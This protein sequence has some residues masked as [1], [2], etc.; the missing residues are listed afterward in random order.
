MTNRSAEKE[1][2]QLPFTFFVMFVGA[3]EKR[4][5]STFSVIP[6]YRRLAADA[7]FKV[8]GFVKSRHLLFL[9][10]PRRRE[11]SNFKNFW[12]P[13][14]RVRG[15]LI[16]KACP[17]LDPGSGMTLRGLFTISSTLNFEP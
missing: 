7:A 6:E 9:S 15:R 14:D 10:F 2:A 1:P 17:G 4:P 5:E 11:S 16:K 12:M 8:D 13:P 3:F